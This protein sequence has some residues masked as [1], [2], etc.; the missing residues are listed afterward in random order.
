MSGAHRLLHHVGPLG[1]HPVLRVLLQEPAQVL[2]GRG[3]GS[4]DL[5]GNTQ[6]QR[7]SDRPTHTQTNGTQPVSSPGLPSTPSQAR[8]KGKER[9][10][11]Q[12]RTVGFNALDFLLVVPLVAFIH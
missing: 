8:R 6:R 2:E 7:P 3:E 10:G 9:R 4:A 11:S 1:G 12:A 5:R